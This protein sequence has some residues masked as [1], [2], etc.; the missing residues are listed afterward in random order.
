MSFLL[1]YSPKKL[2]EIAGN[3]SAVEEIRRWALEWM[4]GNTVQPGKIGGDDSTGRMVLGNA[5]KPLLIYGPT[6]TGKTAAVRALSSE[7]EFE[8]VEFGG[9]SE[10][11]GENAKRVLGGA[12]SHMG[13]F[14][15]K[16]L[17][18]IDDVDAMSKEDSG[19]VEAVGKL[20]SGARQPV[21]LTAIDLYERK[22]S[23]IRNECVKVQMKKVNSGTVAKVLR[24]IAREEGLSIEDERAEEIARRAEGDLRCAI[25]DLEALNFSS[26]RNKKKNIFDSV[27]GMFRAKSYADG[28][29]AT[30]DAEE[31]HDMLK[32]WMDENIP[33][34]YKS[35]EG[36]AAA[37]EMLSRSDVFDGRIMG[38][39]YWGYLKYSSDLMGA[40]VSI[41]NPEKGSGFLMYS[42]PAYLRKMSESKAR[43]E[44]KRRIGEKLKKK[45]HGSRRMLVEEYSGL[46]KLLC[47]KEISGVCEMY[48]LETDEVAFI[49][50]KTEAEV[51]KKLA[52][53]EK[54]RKG[55]KAE[56]EGEEAEE[57]ADGRKKGM[58]EKTENSDSKKEAPAKKA[59]GKK[60]EAKEEEAGKERESENGAEK[61]NLAAKPEIGNSKPETKNPKLETANS[62]PKTE[63]SGPKTKGNNPSLLSDFI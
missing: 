62:K 26:E 34:E 57:K 11:R 23:G 54:G 44:I 52:E 29:K 39:Q 9:E 42:F 37:F 51:K 48:G 61:N 49:M 16:R 32:L 60:K 46:V 24:G 38:R 2:S 40:G 22:L 3:P 19:F 12:A 18:L 21:I 15:G 4:R 35:V 6:G 17:V 10:R 25:N 28:R 53:E 45:L 43:R 56:K 33:L 8:L 20:L 36:Q 63:D 14:G 5:Q 50:G 27:R 31:N 47:G 55:G 58:E 13:L 7:F 41:C 30:L 59:M 1:K